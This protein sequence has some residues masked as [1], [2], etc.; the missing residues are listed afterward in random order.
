MYLNNKIV[1]GKNDDNEYGIILNKANR[2][3][4]ITGASGSGKTVTV[5]VMA[6]SFSDAGVPVFLADVKGDLAGCAV[7]GMPNESLNQRVEKL[8]IDNFEY[9]SFPVHF[10]DLYGKKG[11]PIRTKVE[12]I[13]PEILSIM[14]GLSEAQEGVLTIIFRIAKDENLELCDLKDLKSLLQY[15]SDNRKEYTTKYGTI[16][17]QSI[18]VIQRSLLTLENQGVDNFFGE[19][20]LSIHD[21]IAVNENGKGFINILD[22]VELF[23]SPD[24]YASFLLWLLTELFNTLPEVGDLDKPKVVFFFDEAHLLFNDMPSYR[25]KQITQIV[26]LIRSK[27]IGLYFISQGPTDIPNDISSQLGNRVQHT[28]RAYTPAEQKVVGVAADAFRTNPNFKTKDAILELGIGEALISCLNENGEP[29]IVE[30]VMVLPPQSSMGTIDDITRTNAINSSLLLGKYEQKIDKE[31][32][33]EKVSKKNEEKENM[34]AKAQ[35]EIEEAKRKKEEARLQREAERQRNKDPMVKLGKKVTN[36]AT[37]KLINK[38]L[39]SLF[40]N[41]FK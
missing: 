32:A 25:L 21:F 41:L 11:H 29:E 15:A 7:S 20:S 14:L 4:I 40:K 2:H 37:D 26:K 31:S 23:K 34:A 22:A 35:A 33:F 9:K 18:G 12:T 28:L 8:K 39:N 17:P 5:K 30:K 19:P 24:L 10:W 6:E 13:G 38:G 36:K 27:G 1:I 16:T 3:G